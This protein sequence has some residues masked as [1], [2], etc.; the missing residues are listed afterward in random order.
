MQY[1]GNLKGNILKQVFSG[2]H[3]SSLKEKKANGN[4]ARVI[5]PATQANE[6]H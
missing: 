4:L 1:R 6:N 5:P 3:F 2:I